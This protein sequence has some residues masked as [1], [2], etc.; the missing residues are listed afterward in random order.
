MNFRQITLVLTALFITALCAYSQAPST[1]IGLVNSVTFTD[2]KLGITKYVNANK[3]LT[4]EFTAVENELK[5]MNI[6][7]QTL[8]KEID[9]LNKVA[10]VTDPKVIQGKY[11]EAEKLQRDIKFKSEDA[12]SRYEK[13]Q[14]QL[15]G[16]VVQAIGVGL[17][18]YATQKG[19]ALIFDVAK[20]ENGLLIAVGDQSIDVTKDF[21]TFYNA[22]P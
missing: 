6:R 7:L 11:D 19:Y 17:Q 14:Q 12:K 21:I 5:T 2:E 8:G 3:I 1:R 9:A 13:R 20:D 10:A 16:P 15:L 18:E 22:K 4:G